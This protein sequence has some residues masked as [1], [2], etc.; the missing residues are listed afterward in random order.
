M[1]AEVYICDI[2]GVRKE[3]SNHWLLALTVHVVFAPV[4]DLGPVVSFHPWDENH[5]HSFGYMKHLC[6]IGC[7]NKLLSQTVESWSKPVEEK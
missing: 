4:E 2:C 5:V 7:A 1:R 3:E 6:G